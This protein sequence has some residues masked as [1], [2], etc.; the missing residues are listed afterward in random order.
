MLMNFL[1]FHVTLIQLG[2]YNI[3]CTSLVMIEN[4]MFAKGIHVRTYMYM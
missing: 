3:M 1:C 2:K 4:A